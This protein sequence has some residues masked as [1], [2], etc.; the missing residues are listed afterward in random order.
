MASSF[1]YFLAFYSS[2]AL[3]PI[4]ARLINKGLPSGPSSLSDRLEEVFFCSFP[5]CGDDIT[6]S[7]NFWSVVAWIRGDPLAN[8]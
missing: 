5:N 1:I 7:N 4:E 6:S 2:S 3:C 8:S